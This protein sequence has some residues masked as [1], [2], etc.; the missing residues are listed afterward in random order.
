M[1]GMHNGLSRIVAVVAVMAVVTGQ[2][3]AVDEI[4]AGPKIGTN[5]AALIS[6]PDQN[7]VSQEFKTLA[8]KRGLVLL[9]S[10]SLNW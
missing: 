8:K 3:L 1:I 4:D 10:R 6:A 5:I 2:A 7:G 9:F